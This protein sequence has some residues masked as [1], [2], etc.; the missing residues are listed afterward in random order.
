MKI[1]FLGTGTMGA[2]M[3]RNLAGA[4]HEVAAWNR[5]REKAEPLAAD[6]VRVADTPRE[7]ADGAEVL[8][9]MLTDADAT[10][11]AAPEALRALGDD[12]IWWQVGT[13]GVDG[14]RRAAELADEHG[15]AYVDGPV[16]G[17]KKPAEDAQLLILASGPD[18]ALDRLEP[19][20]DATGKAARRCG[21]APNGSKLKLVLNAWLGGLVGVLAETVA[22]AEAEGVDPQDFLDAIAGGPLDSPYAQLKGAAMAAGE[23]PLSFA[24]DNALKD[25]RFVNDAEDRSGLQLGVLAA[26][27]ELFE[28]ASEQGHGDE[29]LAAVA[30]AV[31]STEG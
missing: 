28:G 21:E 31:R 13:I 10:F 25:L 27:R 2:P 18:G 17:T 20:F 15:V 4:G 26:T 1:G 22:L 7:A 30:E 12:A 8:V 3:A 11:E 5:T 29:D 9:T 14:A 23:Y 6:G 16:S 24:L 19:L